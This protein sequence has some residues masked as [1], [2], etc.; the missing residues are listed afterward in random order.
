MIPVLFST[1]AIASIRN[2]MI[3]AYGSYRRL[4]AKGLRL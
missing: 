4:G 1:Q 2:W 3:A